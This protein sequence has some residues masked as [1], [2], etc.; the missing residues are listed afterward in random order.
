MVLETI[1]SPQDL[2]QLSRKD[3]Q[4]VVDEARQGFAGKNKPAWR[5]QWTKF[6]CS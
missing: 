2:K 1:E 3:L 4:R 5:A 6:W